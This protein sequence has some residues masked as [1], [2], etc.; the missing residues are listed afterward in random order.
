METSEEEAD[1]EAS[2]EEGGPSSQPSKD[3]SSVDE[4]P[5]FSRPPM[6]RKQDRLQGNCTPDSTLQGCTSSLGSK[7]TSK[8]PTTTRRP[9]SPWKQSRV[10]NMPKDPWLRALHALH[11]GARPDGE[12]LP[13]REESVQRS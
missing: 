7:E 1:T 10:L 4:L 13:C 12:T 3:E 8:D 5:K 11:V 2:E 6:K 9:L